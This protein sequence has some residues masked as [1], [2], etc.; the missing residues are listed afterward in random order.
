MEYG[1]D[2]FNDDDIDSEID[3]IN[4]YISNHKQSKN[5]IK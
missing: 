2:K 1:K 5:E 3:M 4:D